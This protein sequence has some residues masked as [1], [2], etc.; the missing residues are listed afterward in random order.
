MLILLAILAQAFVLPT[1]PVVKSSGCGT[2]APFTGLS[3][4]SGIPTLLT[5]GDGT[6]RTLL[7]RVGTAYSNTVAAPLVIII[8]EAGGT[9]AG[10]DGWGI[11]QA[12][13]P[14]ANWISIMPQGITSQTF[15]VG[16]NSTL[17]AKGAKDQY[18]EC[19]GCTP[20]QTGRDA[21]WIVGGTNGGI[22]P[23]ITSHFCVDLNRVFVVGFSWGGDM[24]TSLACGYGVFGSPLV[25]GGIFRS[26]SIAAAGGDFVPDASGLYTD[27]LNWKGLGSCPA[28][29]NW[30]HTY[31]DS[32]GDAAGGGAPAPDLYTAAA[33]YRVNNKCNTTSNRVLGCNYWQGCKAV[34]ADC[35]VN[36]LGHARPATFG[37]DTV[38]FLVASAPQ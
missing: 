34:T 20:A 25:A 18:S 23:Y 17:P 1:V 21:V 8:H 31:D 37:A 13:V 2:T 22:Y 11:S 24:A 6:T 35:P 7:A 4:P 27:Y 19:T 12:A 28:Y 16:W 15:G 36:G 32:G 33:L 9:S 14:A 5:D 10:A 3:T 29:T 38:A 26:G 30:R